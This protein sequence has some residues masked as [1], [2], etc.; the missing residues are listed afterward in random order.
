MKIR[1]IAA[2]AAFFLLYF[3]V[4]ASAEYVTI[5][6][7]ERGVEQSV[8]IGGETENTLWNVEL[9]A[10]NGVTY[11]MT[12]SARSST[13][14]FVYSIVLPTDL[15]LGRYEIYT[16]AIGQEEAL[17]AYVDVVKATNLVAKS[18][19][20]T[21]GH[22][23]TLAFMIFSLIAS[24]R[25]EDF[26]RRNKNQTG[27]HIDSGENHDSIS[28]DFAA[29]LEENKLRGP[30]DALRYGRFIFVRK[31]DAA[32]FSASHYLSTYSPLTSR[33][34]S[35]GSWL[36]AI[37]GPFI[38]LLPLLGGFVGLQLALDT[39]MS[40]SLIPTNLTLMTFA[41]LIGI[42]DAAAGAVIALVYGTYALATQNLVNAIDL[43]S[44]LG[45]S[46]IF[47]A[48]VLL[49]G[50]I[51]PLRRERSN[52]RFVERVADIGIASVFSS[53]AI[54]GIFGAL[55]SIS[56]Q[57]TVLATYGEQFSVIAAIAIG[58]RFLCEDLAHRLAPARLNYLVPTKK[59]PQ[60]PSFFVASLI[61]RVA[62][63]LLFLYGF[64]GFTWQIFL[65][66]A[67]LVI[68]QVLKNIHHTFPNYP[69]LFQILPSGLPQ[70]VF[71]AL[72]GSSLAGWVNSLPLFAEDR[73]KTI[74]VILGIPGLILAILKSF[75]RSPA[76]D[77]VKWYCRPHLRA[78]YH[79]GGTG[80]LMIAFAQASG[81]L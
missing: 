1:F 21:I 79:L 62:I 67:L 56:Q 45:L 34:A 72:L 29:N 53:F 77:D 6:K 30:L 43:R 5:L 44:I 20:R 40:A 7:W 48:P 73:A 50:T 46:L 64:F 58:V 31:L 59:L 60:E 14:F 15:S 11:P 24:T 32:R 27:H 18:D 25:E 65:A 51:R 22:L 55:N 37:L 10:P 80:M 74:L 57:E 26:T 78:L 81:A 4:P 28:V 42:A 16:S 61:L 52:W 35:D 9:K 23:A 2:F 47:F 70:M 54:H 69:T 66:I 75:G 39:D 38:L 49:A 36:Q 33:L 76:P 17:V 13:G 71:M 68:P 19:P 3:S 8:T 63:F 12:R 41:M